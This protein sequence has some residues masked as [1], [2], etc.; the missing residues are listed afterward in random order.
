VLLVGKTNGK[1]IFSSLCTST[2]CI[3][4]L[5]GQWGKH[6]K[7]IHWKLQQEHGVLLTWVIWWPENTLF[8][9]RHGNGRKES[10][11]STYSTWQSSTLL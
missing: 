9:G 2:P 10:Y 4:S 5:Y 6:V 1:C 3:E 7:I 8:P 11:S